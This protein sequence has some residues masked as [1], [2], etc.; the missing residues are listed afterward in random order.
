MKDACADGDA[1]FGKYG[2][3]GRQYTWSGGKVFQS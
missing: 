2:M 1:S 3:R